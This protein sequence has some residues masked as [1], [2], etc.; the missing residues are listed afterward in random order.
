MHQA[1]AIVT[2]IPSASS[3]GM[4]AIAAT[5]AA[6]MAPTTSARRA[7]A[8]NG[9]WGRRS[10]VSIGTTYTGVPGTFVANC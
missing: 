5:P 2:E 4:S 7:D 8:L 6:T 9:T 1:I 10:A 3:A